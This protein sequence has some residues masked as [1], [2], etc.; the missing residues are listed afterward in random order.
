[1]LSCLLIL[2]D[3]MLINLILYVE[4]LHILQDSMLINLIILFTDDWR[5]EISRFIE[6]I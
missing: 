4:L 1:M 6:R 2:K 5:H 3:N